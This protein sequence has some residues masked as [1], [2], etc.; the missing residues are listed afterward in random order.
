MANE[1]L[2]IP[3]GAPLS[4]YQPSGEIEDLLKLVKKD[5]NEG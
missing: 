3:K 2:E 4:A 5:F 1:L